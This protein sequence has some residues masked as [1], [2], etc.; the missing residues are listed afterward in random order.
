[1]ATLITVGNS[2]GERRCDAKCYDASGPDCDCVCGGM[3]HGKGE[4]GAMANTTRYAEKI[5]ADYKAKTGEDAV[6]LPQQPGLFG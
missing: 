5:L 4:A 1:M 3:N 6:I 2:E